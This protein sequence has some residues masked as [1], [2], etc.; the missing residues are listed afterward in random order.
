MPA[1]WVD[2]GPVWQPPI[3][4]FQ[5]GSPTWCHPTPV[6][7]VGGQWVQSGHW[8]NGTDA[9]PW[10][11]GRRGDDHGCADCA[12]VVVQREAA[13]ARMQQL[14]RQLGE[15]GTLPPGLVAPRENAALVAEELQRRSCVWA[16]ACLSAIA[17]ALIAVLAGV[18]PDQH[19]I[20]AL[21]GAII[22]SC[23][24]FMALM[25]VREKTATAR[26]R[27]ESYDRDRLSYERVHQEVRR[28]A[29]T[30]TPRLEQAIE[31]TGAELARLGALIAEHDRRQSERPGPPAS[32]RS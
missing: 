5:H 20:V 26:A 18:D 1:R 25:S 27:R 31:R 22:L 29:A 14:R 23:A 4:V 15:L 3:P 19:G 30:E 13:H 2:T 16:F 12:Q 32:A 7:M 11:P 28:I 21:V 10:A 6:G 9:V 17:A 24:A 8:V